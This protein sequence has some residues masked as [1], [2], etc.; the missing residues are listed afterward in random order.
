MLTPPFN[1]DFRT[2]TATV[3]AG[4]PEE[5]DVLRATFPLTLQMVDFLEEADVAMILQ[6]IVDRFK[7]KHPEYAVQVYR[8]WSGTHTAVPAIVYQPPTV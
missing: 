6:V 5:I 4:P 8:T 3:A 2:M 1:G 7:A